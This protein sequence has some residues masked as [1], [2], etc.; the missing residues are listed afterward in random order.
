M[1]ISTLNGDKHRKKLLTR[2]LSTY[3]GRVWSRF[4][5]NYRNELRQTTH[6]AVTMQLLDSAADCNSRPHRIVHGGRSR[7]VWND[8][9]STRKLAKLDQRWRTSQNGHK[10]LAYGWREQRAINI[11]EL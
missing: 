5:A 10:Y 9:S 3:K 6:S 8:G 11:E 4:I 7:L 2:T 1:V